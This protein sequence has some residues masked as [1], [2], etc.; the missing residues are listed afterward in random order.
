MQ[1]RFKL[2]VT[3]FLPSA[4]G[5]FQVCRERPWFAIRLFVLRLAYF[6]TRRMLF[7][8]VDP[9]GFPIDTHRVLISYWG[10]I[11]EP[12]MRDDDWARAFKDASDP[13]AIDVGANAGVFSY[14]LY[15]LNPSARIFAVEPLPLMANRLQM[16]AA[17][18]GINLN[19]ISAAAGEEAGPAKLFASAPNDTSATLIQQDAQGNSYTVQVVR[20]DDVITSE[21]I[22]LLKVDSE[23]YELPVL[24]GAASVLKRVQYLILE[25]SRLD[26]LPPIVALL[27]P[28]WESRKITSA[29][30]RFSHRPG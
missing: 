24:R 28:T 15:R 16:V 27:G 26:E 20:L 14:L 13:V 12:N 8:L 6:V 3:H 18:V 17:R 11:V 7:C 30:Y 21:K 10:M 1:N 19:V 22:N 25:V 23:H 9:R 4:A 5:W 29:D 2:A